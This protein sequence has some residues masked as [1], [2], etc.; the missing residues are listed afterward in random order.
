MSKLSFGA[1]FGFI[2]LLLAFATVGGLTGWL[3]GASDTPVVAALLPLVFGMT[4]AIGFGYAEAASQLK[5]VREALALDDS[6]LRE[7]LASALGPT[8]KAE[9]RLPAFWGLAVVVFCVTCYLGLQSGVSLRVPQYPS[10]TALVGSRAVITPEEAADLHGFRLALLRQ[11]LPPEDAREIFH[12]VV[13]PFYSDTAY[14]PG[15]SFA[16]VRPDALRQA[17][18]RVVTAAQIP[19]AKGRGPASDT[20]GQ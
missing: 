17:I 12:Q 9:L 18:G 16:A 6:G 20:T 5:L 1:A 8:G 7:R 2:S 11:N 13:A 14:L 19:Q 3:V 4:G 15:G 10:L